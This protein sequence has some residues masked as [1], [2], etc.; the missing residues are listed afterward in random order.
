M[1]TR[2]ADKPHV[3]RAYKTLE[4]LGP[5]HEFS[6]IDEQLRPHPI[7]DAVIKQLCGRVRNTV[8][9][10]DFAL[11]KELQKHVV[12]LKAITPFR[13][14][15]S[16]EETMYGAVLRVSDLLDKCGVQLL[17]LGMH[18][19]L[20]LDEVRVW[21]HRDR[22]IYEAFDKI[23]GLKQHGWVNIQSFQLNIS[24]RNE[25][26]VVKLYNILAEVLPYIP[27][28]SA[29]SPIYESRFG[30]FVDN[31][32]Y[33]Y[34]INQARIPSIAGEI[35]PEPVD[36]FETYHDLTIRKYSKDLVKA[37]APRYMIDKE[38]IN[39]RGAIIRFERRAIE[40]RIMDEQECI[41]SDV[42]LSC[43]IRAL[44]RGLMQP[45][46]MESDVTGLPHSVLVK[47]LNAI[48]RSGLDAKIDH[49]RY[50]TA[51][52][53]CRDLH[54]IAYENGS[55]EEK[56]YL[57][58]VKKRIENGNL[59]ETILKH[60]QGRLQRTDLNEAILNIYSKLSEKLRKNEIYE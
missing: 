12:E 50:L 51:R 19:T 9:F 55:E 4:V 27:A 47:N 58:V 38:W 1:S 7:A 23:F 54:R 24:Y 11:G 42:A 26:E 17:G 39:S 25:S 15:R 52:D 8:S 3:S 6:M 2:H 13:S 40:I 30:E 16:L 48:I 22:Q 33:F 46:K 10:K 59:S 14:P 44:L 29:A 60:V 41:K 34:R 5:E 56:N 45:N 37:K 31:R 53:L 20:S 57:W 36:S 43:F 32:L 18:P 49:P 35:I 21:N 28:I